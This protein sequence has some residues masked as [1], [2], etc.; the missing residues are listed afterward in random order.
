MT[1]N[2]YIQE[3]M[4][5][6]MRAWIDEHK[7]QVEYDPDTLRETMLK[8][9]GTW[10]RAAI[11]RLVDHALRERLHRRSVSAQIGEKIYTFVCLFTSRDS[12]CVTMYSYHQQDG[13]PVIGKHLTGALSERHMRIAWAHFK[14]QVQTAAPTRRVPLGHAGETW[15]VTAAWTQAQRAA[16]FF[17]RTSV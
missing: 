11:D 5:G 14:R 17:D 15:D 16:R 6:I 9:F 8:H 3:R 10:Q 1:H 13:M 12:Y 4:E 7:R 2:E